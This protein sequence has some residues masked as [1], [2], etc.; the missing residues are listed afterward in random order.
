V[1]G[2]VRSLLRG[3]RPVIRSDGRYVRDYIYTRDA[4]RAYMRLAEC[5]DD[6]HVRG[7]AFNFSTEQPLTVLAL[8]REIQRLMRAEHLEPDIRNTAHGEIRDQQ[9][10]AAKARALIGWQPHYSLE[11]GLAETIDW[12]RACL[13]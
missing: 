2:T 4:A 5:L 3:E 6:P 13:S 11:Q 8:V 10:S 1:P 7:E 9:L 12:Y